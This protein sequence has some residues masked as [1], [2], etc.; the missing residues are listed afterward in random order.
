VRWVQQLEASSSARRG[1]A[2]LL[3]LCEI[4]TGILCK[5]LRGVEDREGV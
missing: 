5:E 2:I 1:I 3:P 4:C